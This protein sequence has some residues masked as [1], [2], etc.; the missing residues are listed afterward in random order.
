VAIAINLGIKKVEQQL[1]WAEFLLQ[2][3]DSAVHQFPAHD[4]F[5]TEHA[6]EKIRKTMEIELP[7]PEPMTIPVTGKWSLESWGHCK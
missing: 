3:H 2:V 7:Y 6:F 4:Q 5:T 1:P